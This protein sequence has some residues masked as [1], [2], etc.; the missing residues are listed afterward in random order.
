MVNKIKKIQI[1]SSVDKKHLAM[2]F[3]FSSMTALSIIL[4]VT[5]LFAYFN[6]GF[7][8]VSVNN[9]NEGLIEFFILPFT[10][11]FG[12]YGLYEYWKFLKAYKRCPNEKTSF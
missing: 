3:G 6:N 10:L 12:F 5:F 9:F 2:F 8:T 1:R 11:I 7:V 4:Y